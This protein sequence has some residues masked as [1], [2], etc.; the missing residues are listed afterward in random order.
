MTYPYID[1]RFQQHLTH[2]YSPAQFDYDRA[3]P[4]LA[5]QPLLE[6]KRPSNKDACFAASALSPKISRRAATNSDLMS[7]RACLLDRFLGQQECSSI[8]G[9]LLQSPS[10]FS[11][12]TPNNAEAILPASSNDLWTILSQRVCLWCCTVTKHIG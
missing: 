4:P 10:K 12:P 6:V 3:L 11:I 9:D 1:N 2:T 7:G 5:S 8:D